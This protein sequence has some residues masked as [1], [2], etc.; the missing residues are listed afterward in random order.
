MAWHFRS[1]P[2]RV[3]EA[4]RGLGINPQR[5]ATRVV[6]ETPDGACTPIEGFEQRSHKLMTVNALWGVAF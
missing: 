1:D 3:G 6:F 2:D 4:C 5:S